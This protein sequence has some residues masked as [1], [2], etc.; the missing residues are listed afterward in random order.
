MIIDFH[1]HIGTSGKGLPFRQTEEVTLVE[2]IGAQQKAGID[3]SVI[4]PMPQVYPADLMAANAAITAHMHPRTFPFVWLNPHF[5]AT[6]DPRG[7]LESMLADTLMYSRVYGIKVHPVF[8]GY[9]PEPKCMAPVF[10]IARASQLPVLWHTGWGTFGDP[11]FIEL[12]AKLYPDVI[13]IIG[14]MTEAASP[15]VAS[16]CDNVYL[17]T[18]YCSGPHRL[19]GI[20]GLVGSEKIVFGS[21]FPANSPI[22]QKMIVQEARISDND[23]ERIL[24]RNAQR[25][26]KNA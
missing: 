21:D 17:E 11:F 25:L 18:S 13:V 23:K 8:D 14:H 5:L 4:L 10:E 1:C 7:T 24:G 16:R 9:Y 2:I 3:A 22:V 26:L 20:V 19:A 15:F 12:S 6:H